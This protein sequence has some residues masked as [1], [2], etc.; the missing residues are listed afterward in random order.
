MART[1]PVPE[2]RG[3]RGGARGARLT[4]AERKAQ[5]LAAA[6]AL[7]EESDLDTVSMESVARAAG[8][9]PA[10]L[11]H[12]FGSQH[13]LHHAVLRELGGEMLED[14][15]PDPALSARE[16]LRHALDMFVAQ[17]ARHPAAYLTVVRL[18]QS[19][20]EM[21]QLHRAARA[22][23]T[24]WVTQ[25]LA[26]AGAPVTPAVTLAVRGWLA[27]VEEVVV[28]WLDDRSLMS[29]E[30]LAEQCELAC[31][32]L[33]EGALGDPELAETIRERMSTRPS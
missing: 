3:P 14:L 30:E 1:S 17:V 25:A 22:A 28:I 24:E 2:M 10:L 26:A 9:S 16:Q 23:F 19:S 32:Q 5:I 4:P 20:G 33:V 13:K 27:Y 18:S 29:P 11:F 12:Y 7:L 21:R 15:A 31:V 6:R 8:V